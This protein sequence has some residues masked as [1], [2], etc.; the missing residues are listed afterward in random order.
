MILRR[1]ALFLFAGLGAVALQGQE[2]RSIDL[3]HKTGA[4]GLDD[5][6]FAPGLGKV[7]VPAGRTGQ[8][9]LLDPATQTLTSV[10][11][12]GKGGPS[13]HGEGTTSADEAGGLLVATDRSTL[14]LNVV[15]PA[16]KTIVS[17]A[18]LASGP[19]YVRFVA[20]T[21]EIWVTEPEKDQ[22]EV[23]TFPQ[24]GKPAHAAFIPIA[25]G[26]ES[27]VID[28]PRGRAY[29]HLWKST[30]L[31]IDL[32]SRAVVA[33]WANGCE[34]SRGLALDEAK[35]LLFVGCAEG[36]ATVL[37]LQQNGKLVS[38]LSSGSGV[39]IIDFNPDVRHLYFPGS[40]SGTLAIMA[41]SAS[42]ELSLLGTT[43]TAHG[44]HCVAADRIGNAYVCDP[45]QGQL[46][47]VKDPYPA[48]G[49]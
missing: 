37:D 33:R 4:I 24:G 14:R 30:T 42:G 7:L 39:D 10:E 21:R 41:V 47:V 43:P 6:R 46:L 22:I 29:T 31:A 32:K 48:S 36:K 11:G 20:P 17:F 8:L 34:G 26:P 16:A 12:F 15:D 38:S 5:L 44:G 45:S 1:S 25:D 28:V 40:K 13:G 27:L 23:F 2:T 9:I 49:R 19:D 3:A 35:G 18:A